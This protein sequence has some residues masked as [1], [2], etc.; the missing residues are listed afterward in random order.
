MKVGQPRRTVPARRR[1]SLRFSTKW[2]QTPSPSGAGDPVCCRD[3]FHRWDPIPWDRVFRI[4]F[5]D[6]LGLLVFG[7]LTPN[8]GSQSQPMTCG[9][10]WHGLDGSIC[11]GAGSARGLMGP[12]CRSD[13]L[14]QST[15]TRSG[16]FCQ[17]CQLLRWFALVCQSEATRFKTSAIAN[18]V[19]LLRTMLDIA[20]HSSTGSEDF[21]LIGSIS[22]PGPSNSYFEPR[23]HPRHRVRA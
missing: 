2:A 22:P 18:I 21:C 10:A 20:R 13:S 9:A 11:D 17:L 5:D 14:P 16:L 4:S 12:A 23:F 1:R 15:H 8:P 7:G 6:P 3:V 19:P